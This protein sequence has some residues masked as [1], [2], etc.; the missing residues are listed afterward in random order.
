MKRRTSILKALAIVAATTAPFAVA[1]QSVEQSILAQLT[2]Q[3]FGNFQISR[4]LLGRIRIVSQ[5]G[6][7]TRE[8]VFNPTTGE[9][10]RDYW[11][12]KDG[13]R[14]TPRL[15]DPNDDDDRPRSNSGSGSGSSG[16]GGS[17]SNSGSGSS[18]DDDD[19]DDDN[20]GSGSGNSGSGH[21]GGDDDDDRDDEDDDRDDEDDDRDDDEDEEDDDKDDDD[22]DKDDDRR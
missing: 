18:S 7:L 22:D 1:A 14:A 5:N 13:D 2:N 16:S 10:L 19:D 12:D 20:S 21:S 4:T 17:G 8:I 6:T 11:Q 3:G 15:V 9:I